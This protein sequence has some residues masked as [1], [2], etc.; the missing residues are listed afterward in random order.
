MAIATGFRCYCQ[1][2]KTLQTCKPDSVASYGQ[3]VVIIY[4]GRLSQGTSI[5]QPTGIGRVALNHR[6]IWHFS[7]QGLP[8]YGVATLMRRLLPYV[9]TLTPP[10][11]AGGGYF[12]WHSLYPVRTGFHPLGGAL[13]FAVRTFLPLY[14]KQAITR[15]V[16]IQN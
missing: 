16:V 8:H 7:A 13:P 2:T 15:F 14:C 10:P 5:C 12:L 4:L 3:E 1:L 11:L 6:P 9:F